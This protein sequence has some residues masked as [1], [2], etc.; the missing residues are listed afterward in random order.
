M[1]AA[2]RYSS[3]GRCKGTIRIGSLMRGNFFFVL[4]VTFLFV[5]FSAARFHH[6]YHESAPDNT[7]SHCQCKGSS[8]AP[9]VNKLVTCS[10]L[11]NCTTFAT[12]GPTA[13]T[14]ADNCYALRPAKMMTVAASMTLRHTPI[15]FATRPPLHT[16]GKKYKR[17]TCGD[18]PKLLSP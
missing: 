7:G 17:G 12:Q 15:V 11:V 16:G 1:P 5:M 13:T 2:G 6:H 8:V 4:R 9:L 18:C 14:D 3:L 10:M